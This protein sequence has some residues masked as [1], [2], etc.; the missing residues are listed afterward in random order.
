MRLGQVTA[1]HFG[2]KVF[3]SLLG[4][5]ATVYF[6]R[7][8]GATTLGQYALVLTT[9]TWAAVLGEIGIGSAIKKRVS[10]GRDRRQ[11]LGAGVVLISVTGAFAGILIVIFREQVNAY[12]GSR[13]TELVI[14]IL[15]TA[16]YQSYVSASL[17]G[18]N[19]VHIHAIFASGGQI[20]RAIAQF[21]LVVIGFGLSGMLGGYVI[22]HMIAMTSCLWLFGLRPSLPKTRYIVSL[23]EYAKFA[24]LGNIQSRTFDTFDIA[25]LG[26]FVSQ[27]LIGIYSVTWFLGRFLNFFTNAIST[28]LFPVISELAV[29]D[30]PTAVTD[31]VEEALAYTGIMLI[32]GLIGASVIG[33][34]LLMIYGKSF[35]TGVEILLILIAGFLM[36]A[37]T[38]Q[39]LTVLNAIDRPDLA[40]RV[41]G[42]LIS[43]NVALNVVLIWQ[44]GWT[45]AAIA[46]ALSAV[47]GLAAAFYYTHQEIPFTIPTGEIGR[48]L[49]AGILM[50]GVIYLIRVASNS[51]WISIQNEVFIIVAI[52]VGAGVYLVSLVII[53][54]RFRKVVVQNFPFNHRLLG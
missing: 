3:A 39:L 54:S 9:V 14:L 7:V 36:Y 18:N 49:T 26:I 48:Q 32:P 24:W 53:S 50:G 21:M 52:T 33:D 28:A 51:Y 37:Y 31:L 22:G 43:S 10:E 34:R 1:V 38:R 17:E 8:L 42:A 47:T 4:F 5:S 44:V 29:E 11:F 35:V 16:L 27:D 25:F 40:F 23:F 15:F 2:S 45:G 6:A 41:N 30:S 13:V 46:T 19:L 12:V 20:L